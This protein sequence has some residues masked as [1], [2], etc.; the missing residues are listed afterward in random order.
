MYRYPRSSH[1][2]A[3]KL[4]CPSNS[5]SVPITL[6]VD[7]QCAPTHQAWG[8]LHL[9]VGTLP[10][11]SIHAVAH[12]T[13]QP[14]ERASTRMGIME[15]TAVFAARPATIWA[16]L[17]PA[18]WTAWDPDMAKVEDK[19]GAESLKEGFEVGMTMKNGVQF[20]AHFKEVRENEFYRMTSK[21]FCGMA[22][23]LMEHE[24]KPVDGDKTHV[25]YRFTLN[26]IVGSTLQWAQHGRVADSVK[27]GFDQLKDLAEKAEQG[28]S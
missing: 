13:F 17:A 15:H 20:I 5:A 8:L 23:C 1:L 7:L 24:L 27:L 9:Y 16:L 19:P 26:G 3:R 22:G 25:T 4:L 18:K 2:S 14:E 6:R 10:R 11:A 12:A 28:S 21:F